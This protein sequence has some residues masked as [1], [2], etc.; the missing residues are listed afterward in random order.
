MTRDIKDYD[1]LTGIKLA[2]GIDSVTVFRTGNQSTTSI[3]LFKC[4]AGK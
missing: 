4:H 2:V 3:E 1:N